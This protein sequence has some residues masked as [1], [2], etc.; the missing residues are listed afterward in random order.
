VAVKESMK[1]SAAA[2]APSL[3]ERIFSDVRSAIVS[4]AWS[5]GHRIPFEHEFSDQYACS[6]MT[7]NKALSRLAEAGLIERRR[8]SGSFVAQPHTQSAVLKISDVGAEV[9]ALGLKHRFEV[10][11][12][13]V[14]RA[15]DRDRILL[16][17]PDGA[18]VLAID[19]RHFAGDAPFCL[20]HRLVSLAA[21]P[22]AADEPFLTL[23]PGAWLIAKAPWTRAENV[24]SAE[25]ASRELAEALGLAKGGAILV[26]VRRTWR[27][28][29]PVTRVKL[30]YAKGRELVARFSPN[31]VK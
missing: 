7:V 4:G 17:L 30:S 3:H 1:R 13:T 12:R 28:D 2:S 5:P 25:N 16:D 20:E 24:I 22:E 27:D 14:R 6:R 31:E 8:R 26:V 18:R 19:C 29:L 15:T 21:V 11:S 23:P 10:L 9:A